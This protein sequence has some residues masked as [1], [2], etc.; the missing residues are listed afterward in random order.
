MTLPPIDQLAFSVSD[1]SDHVGGGHC[2]ALPG[3]SLDDE[4]VALVDQYFRAL[5]TLVETAAA[6]DDPSALS[7]PILFT[8]HH[9]CEVSLKAAILSRV[10]AAPKL[11]FL[12]ELWTA[13]VDAGCF[14]HLPPEELSWG[15]DFATNLG[16]ISGD[17][18]PGRYVDGIVDGGTLDSQWCCLNISA[19][20]AAA[21]E[22]ASLCVSEV[23]GGQ[24]TSQA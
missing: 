4:R 19:I 12:P 10:A 16:A 5:S 21:M 13:A 17:G 2:T 9:L 6:L 22:F 24:V 7:R 23:T 15:F 1:T 20:H 14:A 3:S 8:A 18:T 11:H